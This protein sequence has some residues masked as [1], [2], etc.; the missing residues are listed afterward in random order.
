MNA[1]IEHIAKRLQQPLPGQEAQFR[2][3]HTARRNAAPIPPNARQAA[4]LALFFPKNADWHLVF[5]ERD[6]SNPNDRHGG[7]ISFPGGKYE[8]G[9]QTLENTALREAHEEVG[10]DS[11]KVTLLGA[12]TS[13]YIP[14]SNFQ[15]NPFVGVADYEP[16]F[17]PQVEEV[18]SILEV[19]F[20]LLQNADTQKVTNLQLS[21]NLSLQ[22]VP[23][24]DV[25]GKVLWGATAMMLSEL[26]EVVKGK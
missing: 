17:N 20:H 21:Q 2:M 25:F 14:V 16:I 7:Q 5:I 19:P 6:A 18:S 26:L 9:D 23:Y 1:F 22:G 15:V 24:F 4:V 3:A 13:L 12:L 8:E 11:Q 10:V